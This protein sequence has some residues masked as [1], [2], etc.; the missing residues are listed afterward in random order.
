MA[1]LRREGREGRRSRIGAPH[2]QFGA[3]VR[4]EV[5]GRH[6]A[7]K[8]VRVQVQITDPNVP[9]HGV[10]RDWLPLGVPDLPD[11][12]GC[13]L[14]DSARSHFS[15]GGPSCLD[16]RRGTQNR[17]KSDRGRNTPGSIQRGERVGEQLKGIRQRQESV[18]DRHEVGW[19]IV[20]FF[21]IVRYVAGRTVGATCRWLVFGGLF[22]VIDD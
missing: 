9:G 18:A 22:D 21:E 1:R 11:D 13:G 17:C 15:M 4:R 8:L 14:P 20:P 6:Q 12:A 5:T 10:I 2:R 7:Q 3:G 16:D 19:I